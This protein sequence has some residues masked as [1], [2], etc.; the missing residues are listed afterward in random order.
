[1][2]K[3]G[4]VKQN[5]KLWNKTRHKDR[6]ILVSLETSFNQKL[7]DADNDSENPLLY[8]AKINAGCILKQ[9]MFEKYMEAKQI[10]RL[11]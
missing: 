3:L 10:S 9:K 11:T 2:I 1:M 6:E 8:D 5:L 7:I 4:R